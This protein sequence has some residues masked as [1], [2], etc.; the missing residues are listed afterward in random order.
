MGKV[1]QGKR[2][3]A[4]RTSGDPMGSKV[5]LADE[6]ESLK[7]AKSK[8]NDLLN[9]NGQNATSG[10]IIRKRQ[11]EE[12]EF[13]G[14][15]MTAKILLQARRQQSELQDE[16]GI[17]DEEEQDNNNNVNKLNRVGP[18]GDGKQ[19]ASFNLADNNND[20]DT[21]NNNTNFLSRPF[22][23]FQTNFKQQQKIRKSD[24]DDSDSDSDTDEQLEN[25]ENKRDLF[26]D[27]EIQINDDDQKAFDTFMSNKGQAR[28]TIADIIKE[29]LTE[30]KN[31]TTN[32]NERRKS[33][34]SRWSIS[35]GRTGC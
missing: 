34:N 33:H 22:K 32:S 9:K 24:H 21:I 8:S 18:R 27:E 3:S 31:R 1:K 20:E 2:I 15:K 14:E 12:D 11:A 19:P 25:G 35:I 30:K 16:Y 5:P 13:V 4:H 6:I 28:R 17:G 29:K 26:N 10:A 23:K 7:L